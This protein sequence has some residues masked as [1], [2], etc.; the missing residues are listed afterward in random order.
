MPL[1][2]RNI[3]IDLDFSGNTGDRIVKNCIKKVYKYFKKEVTIKFVLHFQTNKLCYFNNTKDK[4]PFLSQS[5]V[6][7]KSVYPG[8]KSCMLVKQITVY[9]RGQGK[10]PKPS[11]TRMNKAQYM[12]MCHHVPITATLQIYSRL[13]PIALIPTSSTYH[14]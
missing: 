3:F 14:K 4:T 9:M 5:S 13:A 11:V 1:E 2:K 6:I 12:N 8:R 7:H 10:T